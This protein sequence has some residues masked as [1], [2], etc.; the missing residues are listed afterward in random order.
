MKKESTEF[1]SATLVHAEELLGWRPSQS[2]ITVI[3]MVL[4]LFGFHIHHPEKLK[5]KT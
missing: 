5:G 3:T 2:M 4:K 1:K